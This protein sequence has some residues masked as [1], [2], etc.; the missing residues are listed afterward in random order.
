MCSLQN[1]TAM[2]QWHKRD[3]ANTQRTVFCE[4]N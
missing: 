1:P 4:Q 3:V 2:S